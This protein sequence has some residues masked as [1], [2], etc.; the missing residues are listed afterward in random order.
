[1]EMD[2]NPG[3]QYKLFQFLRTRLLEKAPY[4]CSNVAAEHGGRGFPLSSNAAFQ[5]QMKTV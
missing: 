2:K 3:C 5:W 1:M 4:H